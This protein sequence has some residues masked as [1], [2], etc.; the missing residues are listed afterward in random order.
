MELTSCLIA[1]K[2]FPQSFS[3]FSQTSNA[4]PIE[5]WLKNQLFCRPNFVFLFIL[6]LYFVVRTFAHVAMAH[7]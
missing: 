5:N 4:F 6:L 7:S 2:L 1:L 3:S